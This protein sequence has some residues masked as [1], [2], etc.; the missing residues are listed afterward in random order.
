MDFLNLVTALNKRFDIPIPE[1]DYPQ[2]G[3]F[4]EIAA[5][6]AEKTA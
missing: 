2:L 4:A 5:Y 6:L 3:S 1:T